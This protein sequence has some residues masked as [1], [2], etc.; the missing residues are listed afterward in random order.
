M[1]AKFYSMREFAFDYL[2]LVETNSKEGL[3]LFNSQQSYAVVLFSQGTGTI[4]GIKYRELKKVD[5]K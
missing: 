5:S 1:F 3:Q 2:D 4:M